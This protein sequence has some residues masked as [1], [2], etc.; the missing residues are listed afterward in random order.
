M[1]GKKSQ[2]KKLHDNEQKMATEKIQVDKAI[3]NTKSNSV[4]VERMKFEPFDGD[5]RK[6]P[7]F[8]T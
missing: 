5:I 8:K 4:Q 3:A 7:A 2:E 1:T 6:Y